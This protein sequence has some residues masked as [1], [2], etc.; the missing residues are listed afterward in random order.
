VIQLVKMNGRQWLGWVKVIS[1]NVGFPFVEYD[2]SDSA[3]EDEW[4]T[5][6][7]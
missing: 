5:V 6:T 3:G 1:N 4:A 7:G 2:D